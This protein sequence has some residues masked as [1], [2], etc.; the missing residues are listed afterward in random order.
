MGGVKRAFNLTGV[1]L[2]TGLGRAPLA[3]EVVA[4]MV[5]ASRAAEVE[6]DVPTGGRGQRQDAVR[7]RCERLF[8]FPGCAFNNNAAATLLTL[9]AS[10]AGREVVVG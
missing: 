10:A 8:G 7:E 6:M 4:A 3:D 5:G 9:A 2:H 1:V